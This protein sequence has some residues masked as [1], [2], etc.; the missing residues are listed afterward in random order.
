MKLNKIFKFFIEQV[1]FKVWLKIIV[2]FIIQFSIILSEILFLSVFFLVLNQGLD[3]SNV[4]III[5]KLEEYIFPIFENLSATEVYILMLIGILLLKNILLFFQNIYYNRFIFK[6]TADKSAQIL[7]AYM[8]KSY[9]I[10]SKKEISIYI[11][12]LIK[13]VE[14]V[15]VGI[16]GLIIAFVGELFYIMILTYY[17][18]HLINFNPM[19]EVYF[20]VFILA[21]ILYYLFSAAEKYGKIRAHNEIRF[22]KSAT[23]TLNIFKEIKLLKSSKEFI[24]R[25]KI[26]LNTFYS[27]RIGVGAIN[28]TPKFM[29]EISLFITFFIIYKN[30]SEVININD[31][32]MKYSVLALALIRLI[33]SFARLSSYTTT[34]LYNL[35]SIEYIEKDL[36]K[37]S[38]KNM[39]KIIKKNK[40]E[41]MRIENIQLD[42]I[43]KDKNQL[44]LKFHNLNLNLQKNKI[45]GIYGASGSGK[46][47]LLNILS[48]FI[49]PNKG[50]IFINGKSYNFY[51][52][53]KKFKIG[54][55]P[56]TPTILDENILINST[57][58]FLNNNQEI[59]KL[60]QY[61]NIFNL[62]KFINKKYF[63]DKSASS[64]KNMSGGE[65]QRIGLLRAFINEPDLILLDEPTSSLDN[66]NEKAIFKFLLSIKKN[67][68]IVVASHKEEQKKYFDEIINL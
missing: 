18:S 54:Y 52:L 19:I 29:F 23:D 40:I 59:K 11:K 4:E 60:K 50:K 30:E 12:Q 68:I 37:K 27:S 67:K 10:F 16:F 46:S 48:G 55:A 7:K 14:G 1:E 53:T 61:L 28:L 5:K 36:K 2:N 66:K 39:N 3:N 56:Q 57:L 51:D 17:V 25:Y 65:K 41:T 45:Y 32:V 62:K 58:K 21:L 38:S 26:F 9:D 49:K 33:P 63:E 20:V 42:Y 24:N 31:F 13:D 6:L 64:I 44:S 43:K 15:F 22:F 35:N 8:D 34:I 47:S